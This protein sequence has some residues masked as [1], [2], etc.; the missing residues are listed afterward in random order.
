MTTIKSQ[1]KAINSIA[2]IG[3][4]VPRQCGIATFTTDLV[5]S[6]SS[7]EPDIESW[8]LAM[9][10]KPDGYRYPEKVRFAINQDRIADYKLAAEFINMHETDFVCVQHEY[11]IFGG[12]AGSHLLKLLSE[13][14]KPVVTTLHTVLKE[15]SKEN[16]EVLLKL[17]ELSDKLVVMSHKAVGFLNEIYGIPAEKINFIPHGIPDIPFIDPNYYKDQFGVEGNKVLLTFGL[18]SPNKGL[19]TM[20]RAL[21]RVI[22]KHPDVIY[23]ILGATHPHVVKSS[24]EGYRNSF[25]KLAQELNITDHVVFKNRFV[26]GK[27]LC[28]FLGAAD[29]YITPYLDEAQITSGTL[30]YAMG[31]G[32]AVISTP[33]WYAT[34]M[35]A[36]ARGRLVPFKDDRA[37]AEQIIALLDNDIERNAI[38]K[39]AYSFSRNAVWKEVAKQYLE[40]FNEVVDNRSIVPN[41]NKQWHRQK[42]KS[43]IKHELPE[44]K[45]DYL[46]ALTDDTGIFQHAKYT[47][48]NR[49]HGYCTDDCSRALIAVTMATKIQ[50][51]NNLNNTKEDL[52]A[53]TSR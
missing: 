38:R 24:G 44:L 47:I 31:A 43:A 29:L 8:V 53:L 23:I 25:K 16:R 17:A 30:A 46:K 6:I 9:N 18:L 1:H 49:D 36:E 35:L 41:A 12:T 4:Y 52:S 21:P 20:L 40:V 51:A 27:K 26:A 10:D 15:P 34:E 22:K 13:V 37:I 32:K 42:F 2:F 39:Q 7:V 33:Y 45:L 28:E 3:N 5:E 50:N 19:E 11:G 48:P 14:H